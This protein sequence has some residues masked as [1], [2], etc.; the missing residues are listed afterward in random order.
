M[1]LRRHSSTG[2]SGERVGGVEML[3]KLLNKYSGAMLAGVA[4]LGA[5]TGGGGYLVA[6]RKDVE[7]QQALAAKD[8]E[9]V[10]KD[11]E[12]VAKDLEMEKKIREA[13]ED[14]LKLHATTEVKDHTLAFLA[15]GEYETLRMIKAER[16]RK[17]QVCEQRQG[18]YKEE[19]VYMCISC[20]LCV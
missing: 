5:A 15:E 14:F 16:K 10:A 1:L 9:I 7:K 4:I 13:R 17:Q 18:A 3:F 6:W 19:D 12:M 11:L 2:E 20:C 8:L